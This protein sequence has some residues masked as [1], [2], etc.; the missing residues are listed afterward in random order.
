MNRLQE[1]I[2]QNSQLTSITILFPQNA[3]LKFTIY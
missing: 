1:P 2:S 3:D